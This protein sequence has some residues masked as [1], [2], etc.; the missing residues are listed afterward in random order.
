MYS[1]RCIKI[2]TMALPISLSVFGDQ[3][4][5]LPATEPPPGFKALTA[6][7]RSLVDIYFGG[8][9]V[10]SQIASFRPGFI[11]LSNPAEIVQ[12]IGDITL[13]EQV[14]ARL[15]GEL[16]SNAS[17][18]CLPGTTP[19]IRD[20]CG[21]LTPSIAGVIFDESRFRV[22][23]F[24]NRRFMVTRAAEVRKY[25][26][27]SD[28]GFALMQNFSGAISGTSSSDSDN[29]YTITGS[30]MAAWKENSLQL[31][32][33]YSNTNHFS[34]DQLYGQ[35]DFEG[36]EYSVGLLNTSGF[37]FNFT[38]DQPMIG[39]RI[40]SSTATREDEAFTSSAPLEVFLPTRGR[41]EIFR[42]GRLLDSTFFE[43]GAQQLDTSTLPTG[44]YDIE[45][46]V[47]DEG[48]S[49]ISTETRFFAKQ[50]QIPPIGEW[51]FFAESGRLVTRQNDGALPDSTNQWLSRAGVNRRVFDTLAATGSVA[52]DN[53]DALMEL[54]LYHFGP[55]YEIT[56][57]VMLTDDGS[58]GIFLNGRLTLGELALSGNYRRLSR[59]DNFTL[60]DED[61]PTMLG[62]GFRQHSASLS[63]PLFGGNLSYR[64]S[65]NQNENNANQIEVPTR[66]H[67]VDYRRQLFRAKDYDGDIT[68]SFSKS[69]DT[70][71]ALVSLVMRYRENNWD[72]QFTPQA[73]M[74][75][76]DNSRD[77]TERAR[78][79]ASWDDDELLAADLQLDAGIETG[80]GDERI[81][82]S[83]RYA[84]R[85]GRANLS[86]AHTYGSGDSTTSWAGSMSTSFLTDGEVFAVGGEESA[87]S[88][89]VINLEGRD[90]DVFDVEINDQRRGYAVA[91]KPSVVALPPFEQYR[92]TLSPAGT[93]LY[94]FDE[95]EKQV[96]LYP[97]NV[98]TLDYEATPLQLLFGQ[99]TFK[100]KPVQNA[101]LVGGSYP[102]NTDMIGMFQLESK[103]D[104]KTIRVE[105]ESDW[106]CQLP[107]PE[108]GDSY[109]VQMGTVE[110]SSSQC[111]LMQ[112][113]QLIL[114]KNNNK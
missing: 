79:S 102:S 34:V 49:L 5:F 10:T 65:L 62:S 114:S 75:E 71:I 68:L 77:R 48:G 76:T 22:D 45:I 73:Q 29:N 60:D 93:T 47:V 31:D 8:R 104:I 39:A 42:D 58:A 37:G 24:I 40:N 106:V 50:S 63:H 21:L 109:I 90:G 3:P 4:L 54:G 99:L 17:E 53:S 56:Q 66:T 98:V 19:G 101:N 113:E 51:L 96:T 9:Y 27:P 85:Y 92:V 87:D 110:L 88:A 28:A 18:V 7:Q 59:P 81:D 70:N 64:Y 72:L 95:R 46:R 38:S 97:G 107:I 94:S 103:A 108:A 33:D 2:I 43:A 30:T 91:G 112:E 32:W 100:G 67:S 23:V 36:R 84:N 11:E 41:V 89:I 105:M 14:I 20:N 25:L 61:N 111:Q 16:N 83:L 80:S 15:T 52:M 55:G 57:S 35:R 82:G 12:R 74:T 78:L 86:A 44:A 13:S 26:P 6:G 1:W 69:G